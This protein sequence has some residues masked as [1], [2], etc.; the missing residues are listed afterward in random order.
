MEAIAGIGLVKLG[1]W[2]E[3]RHDSYSKLMCRVQKMIAGVVMAEKEERKK[4]HDV[5][6]A[7][8]GYDPEK[9]LKTD[10]E[11]RVEELEE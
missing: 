8:L 2:C 10:A 9:L 11:I 7:L 5:Q 6:K 3:K 1:K 4:D